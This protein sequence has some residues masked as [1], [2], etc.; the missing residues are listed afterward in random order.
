MMKLE[1]VKL[2]NST[3][4]GGKEITSIKDSDEMTATL[5]GKLILIEDDK[6]NLTVTSL[7]N[8]QYFIPEN[9]SEFMEALREQTTTNT[10]QR[11]SDKRV[12]GSTKKK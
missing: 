1:R 11:A 2:F 7:Y 4:V 3:K 10:I 12:K 5:S 6:G 9:K 8:C